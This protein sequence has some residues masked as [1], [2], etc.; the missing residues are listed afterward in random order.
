MLL[1]KVY[2]FTP[3]LFILIVLTYFLDNE[4]IEGPYYV[5]LGAGSTIQAIRETIETRSVY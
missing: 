2:S 5:H 3:S 4:D 1:N